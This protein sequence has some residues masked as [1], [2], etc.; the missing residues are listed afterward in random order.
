MGALLSLKKKILGVL[1]LLTFFCMSGSSAWP[2]LKFIP[3]SNGNATPG[4]TLAVTGSH[5]LSTL[6]VLCMDLYETILISW[7]S[8]YSILTTGLLIRFSFKN[9]LTR[10]YR[11]CSY[12][13]YPHIWLDQLIYPSILHI[14]YPRH[15]PTV[16]PFVAAPGPLVFKDIMRSEMETARDLMGVEDFESA[17]WVDILLAK[18]N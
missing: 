4:I 14:T 3:T 8:A 11:L 1:R 17:E 12:T 2:F 7:T 15:S 10:T 18:Q 16:T 9:H 13:D 5:F 6:V